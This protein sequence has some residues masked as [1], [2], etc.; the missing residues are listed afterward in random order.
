MPKSIEALI[1]IELS[2]LNLYSIDN[3]IDIDLIL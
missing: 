3:F 2:I 1:L